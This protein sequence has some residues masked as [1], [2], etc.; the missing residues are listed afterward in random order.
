MTGYSHG[1][2]T[3][4]DYATLKYDS[5]TGNQIWLMR[6]DGGYGFDRANAIALDAAGNVYV[7]GQSDDIISFMDYAT[8]K[9]SQP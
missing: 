1:G 2:V 5:A 7:T 4:Y 3:D 6:Y 9:Y 8:I